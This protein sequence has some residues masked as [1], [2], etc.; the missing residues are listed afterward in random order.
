M[1]PMHWS[2]DWGPWPDGIENS[3]TLCLNMA[4]GRPSPTEP[5]IRYGPSWRKHGTTQAPKKHGSICPWAVGCKLVAGL[6]IIF[7]KKK[8]KSTTIY[9]PTRQKILNRV[10]LGLYT[11]ARQESMWAWAVP[12][13]PFWNCTHNMAWHE[14][15]TWC[16]PSPF[17][18]MTRELGTHDSPTHLMTIFTSNIVVGQAYSWSRHADS[19]QNTAQHN[20]WPSLRLILSWAKPI[21]DNNTRTHH[22]PI[23]MTY[24]HLYEWHYYMQISPILLCATNHSGRVH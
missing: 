16:G 11:K 18:P 9:N 17:R 1:V 3:S 20:L 19:K 24:D 8:R 21:Q 14:T 6:E 10:K 5:E 23:D 7:L 4:L 12:G 15:R 2:M 22:G 13:P